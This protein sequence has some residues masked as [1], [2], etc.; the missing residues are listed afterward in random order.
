MKMLL[1]T[2]AWIAGVVATILIIL[3]A[4]CFLKGGHLFGVRYYSNYF[5]IAN[6]LYFLA[7]FCFMAVHSHYCGNKDKAA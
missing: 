3:G 1:K 2:I 6:S 7:I 5:Y 4:I